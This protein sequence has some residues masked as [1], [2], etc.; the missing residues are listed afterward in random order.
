MS[1]RS[2]LTTVKKQSERVHRKHIT[3]TQRA[4]RAAQIETERKAAQNIA[5][6]RRK[7]GRRRAVQRFPRP[8]QRRALLRRG[9]Q[10]RAM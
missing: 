9:A 8:F 4:Q 5:L 6:S 7:A 3:K 1:P 10:R 2:P